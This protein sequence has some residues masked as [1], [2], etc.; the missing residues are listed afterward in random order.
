MKN[1]LTD[2]NNHLFA[3][4]ER[5]SDEDLNQDSLLQE[6]ARSGAITDVADK[7]I[8]NA[9]L[10]YKAAKLQADGLTR[11]KMPELLGGGTDD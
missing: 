2:L 5:L 7:V 6:I 10:V 3:Q 8:R 9:D 11:A 1:K 4:L